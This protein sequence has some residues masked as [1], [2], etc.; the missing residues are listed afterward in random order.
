MPARAAPGEG[1]QTLASDKVHR[2]AG[3]RGFLGLIVVLLVVAGGA[4]AA[5]AFLG[6]DEATVQGGGIPV[7]E[8]PGNLLDDPS[9]EGEGALGWEP[10]EAAPE[11]F[12]RDSSFRRAGETGLGA[13]LVAGDWARAAAPSLP[14]RPRRT[15]TLRASL[16]AEG[17]AEVAV[18]LEVSAGDGSRASFVAWSETVGDTG[19]F[20]D[21]E[22][23]VGSLPG[24]DTL[25]VV[26]EAR[27]ADDG[28]ASLDD[29][30][31]V[32]EQG[33]LSPAAQ[34]EEVGLVFLGDPPRTAC[35]ARSSEVVLAG[36]RLRDGGDAF[37]QGRWVDGTLAAEPTPAGVRLSFAGRPADAVL[38]ILAQ[39]EVG[40][41]GDDFV[42]TTGPDG[43]RA[44]SS[45]FEGVRADSLLLGRGIDLMRLGFSST[46]TLDG[47][48]SGGALRVAARL[49]EA[50]SVDFQLTFREE[51]KQAGLL[52]DRARSEERS[53][54]AG[55]ALASWSEL[56]NTYPFEAQ[57]VAEAET[58][59]ARLLQQGLSRLG[60]VRAEVER[61]GFFGLADLFRQCQDGARELADGYAG[62]EVETEALALIADIEGRITSLEAGRADFERAPA[63]GDPRRGR[64]PPV[65][66][67]GGT[68][69]G[70]PGPPAPPAHQRRKRLRSDPMAK[71]AT[72]I[73][74]GTRTAKALRG[75]VKGKHLRR[76]RVRRR[77]ERRR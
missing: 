7:V 9:F 29:V 8:V 55:R 61:A 27:A 50:E 57:L 26:V 30:S 22:L 33:E 49:G 23:G 53:G 46:V 16:S 48:L 2:A 40:G 14:L 4:G 74:I 69:A 11:A 35:L 18:G 24:Y 54:D 12:F 47:T 58:S 6:G 70:R 66:R 32:E 56:L 10:A 59:R 62:S 65:E 52:A 19:G 34:F 68:P 77:G 64:G 37:G 67:P 21:V 31:L 3:K 60:E 5:L 15:Y 71:T 20:E 63:R 28:S 51:R 76:Q 41:S 36:I 75:H 42:A 44:Y 13:D 25:R 39:G 45:S 1:L 17:G 38:R 72:G 73:D 43:F